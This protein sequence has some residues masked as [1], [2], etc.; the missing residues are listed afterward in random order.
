MASTNTTQPPPVKVIYQFQPI[1]IKFGSK[2]TPTP[3]TPPTLY[4]NDPYGY[5]LIITVTNPNTENELTVDGFYIRSYFGESGENNNSDMFGSNSRKIMCGKADMC[6][7]TNPCSLA[8]GS[9]TEISLSFNDN[10]NCTSAYD[11]TTTIS[12]DDCKDENLEKNSDCI[13]ATEKSLG[14]PDAQGIYTYKASVGT[15]IY[16]RYIDGAWEWT[17]YETQIW[18]PVTT[19]TVSGG[20][21]NG[22]S[23]VQEQ[24]DMI[25]YLAE[26]NPTP[27]SGV[28]SELG[29][30]DAQGIYTY[31]ASVGTPIYYRYIDGAWEWT[32]YET[33]IWM[34]VTTTTVSGGSYNGKSPTQDN[35][36]MINYLAENNPTSLSQM[37]S[38]GEIV[39][40]SKQS[41]SCLKV[42]CREKCAEEY[43][44][45][46]FAGFENKTSRQCLCIRNV[47]N[48]TDLCCEDAFG[49]EVNIRFY[50][51][52]NF[53]VL[54]IGEFRV[55]ET[56]QYLNFEPA[57]FS[58]AG[59]LVATVYFEPHAILSNKI[60]DILM[61]VNLKND[62]Y[63]KININDINI[64]QMKDKIGFSNDD[65]A[66][67]IKD[68]TDRI[69]LLNS[70]E[71][72]ESL[73]RLGL[74]QGTV[75]TYSTIRM[76]VEI[77]YTYT[78]LNS[79]TLPIV[80]TY[81]NP[82]KPEQQSYI[83]MAGYCPMA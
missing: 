7:E 51:A 24:I 1:E 52:H 72:R 23:P 34:P 32:P 22:K 61:Y 65:I 18:M 71:S 64:E 15:P 10:A 70:G 4:A 5:N 83:G 42:L 50:A 13:L 60:R 57:V 11:L 74:G 2:Y 67:C 3:F 36:D 33:Q 46:H 14:Q 55:V 17:P 66:T 73:C 54:G 16:Y 44:C 35:I 40:C 47:N 53:S 28:P 63:G 48:V 75:E 9:D 38:G 56:E 37:P 68:T 81:F 31:K 45:V 41:E 49:S 39:G 12:E 62:G 20:S 77:N 69:T 21:Y 82:N 27:P 79:K 8:P 6:N 25:N 26:N 78:W 29:Q 59:P 30:P 80:K 76:N 43:P 19:T 58:S